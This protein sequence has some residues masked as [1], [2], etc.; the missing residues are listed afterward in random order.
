MFATYQPPPYKATSQNHN[1][2]T[3]RRILYKN[4]IYESF[5]GNAQPFFLFFYLDFYQKF[6][7]L[8]LIFFTTN[9]K[10]ALKGEKQ[11]LLM[12][13]LLFY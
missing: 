13:R 4:S 12:F 11:H 3:N 9:N 5:D 2:F 7:K 1:I 10:K 6:V 8:F